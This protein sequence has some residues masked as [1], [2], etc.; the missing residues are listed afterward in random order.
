MN[1]VKEKVKAN[2]AKKIVTSKNGAG[3]KAN[4]K[5]V[6]T[7]QNASVKEFDSLKNVAGYNNEELAALVG[8]THRTIRNKKT[9][10][11]LFDIAQT[12]RLRKLNLL[13]IEGNEV[14][15]NK[16]QFHNWLQK[17]AYGLDYNT[18]DELLKQPGG[19]DKVLNEVNAIKFGDTI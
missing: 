5:V 19:L 13:F 3:H 15:G 1:S 7:M 17:P 11:E 16:E 12:E 10:N 6:H 8:I 9:N 14:F 18:P 2:P 4:G